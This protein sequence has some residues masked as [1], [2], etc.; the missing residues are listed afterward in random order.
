MN[1]RFAWAVL[2][3]AAVGLAAI[4]PI[5]HAEVRRTAPAKPF[6]SGAQRS[7]QVLRE[8]SATLRSIDARLARLETVVKRLEARPGESRVP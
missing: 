3:C 5:A 8:I 1:R 7:E 6:T 4:G 2:A